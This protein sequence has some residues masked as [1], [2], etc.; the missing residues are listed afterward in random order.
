MTGEGKILLMTADTQNTLKYIEI[1]F[2]FDGKPIFLIGYFWKDPGLSSLVKNG[3]VRPNVFNSNILKYKGPGLRTKKSADKRFRWTL[4]QFT[5]S[6][7]VSLANLTGLTSIK[8]H[9][10]QNG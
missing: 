10:C 5:N 1:L 7:S 2:I 4:M 8:S 3:R 6:M 9:Q